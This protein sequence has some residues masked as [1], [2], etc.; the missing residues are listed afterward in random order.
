MNQQRVAQ[1]QTTIQ[2]T[3]PLA[4]GIL[5]R[6]CAC[7]QLKSGGGECEKCHKKK[8]NKSLQTK[9]Q[10]GETNDSYEQEADRVSERVMRM[11]KLKDSNSNEYHHAEPLVQRQISNTQSGIAEVPAIVHDVLS[12]PGQSLDHVTRDF[13]EP[14]FGYDFEKVRIH[15]DAKAAKSAQAVNAKAYTVGNNVVFGEGNYSIGNS[16]G[17]ALLAHELTH[18]VQQNEKQGIGVI[19]RAEVDDRSCAGLTDIETDIDT[20]VNAGIAAARTA[21]TTPMVVLNFLQDVSKRLGGKLVGAIEL[22]I[23]NMS[24]KKRKAPPQNLSG[25]KFSGVESVNRFFLFHTNKL[26]AVVG[27]SAKV[28]NICI[29]ADKLGH[30]FGEGFTYF[31]IAKTSGGGT[32]GTDAAKSAGR[33]L[34]ISTRQGLGVTGVFSNA[35]LA[36][37]LAG[38]KFYEDLEANPSGLTFKIGNYITNKWNETVNPSFYASSEAN[39]IWSNLLTG[40]WNGKFTSASNTSTPTDAIVQLTATTAGKVSGTNKWP[41]SSASPNNE[42]IKNGKITK[43][44]TSVT[45]K[46]PRT[47]STPASTL[48]A[49][50]VSGVTIDFDWELRKKSGKGKWTSVDEQNLVGTWGIGSSRVNGGK[51]SLKKT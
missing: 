44:I 37:N 40:K 5:Q 18:V 47:S 9:L 10:I 13:M 34:E 36:A 38:K 16:R 48:S 25:T 50:P 24:A 41:A 2:T 11:P 27:P 35:D 22:F 28:K 15:T 49:S 23:Q 8:L 3:F 19:Q 42:K 43:K 45:G 1:K 6:K 31:I 39:V 17:K 7:G 26:A 33:F 29:G 30:F 4:S 21:A 32:T 14:R 46:F 20:K 12:T 51:W